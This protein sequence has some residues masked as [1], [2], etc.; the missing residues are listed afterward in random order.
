M[1]YFFYAIL[2]LCCIQCT[3]EN[4][5]SQDLSSHIKKGN[6]I[7]ILNEGQ[8]EKLNGEISVYRTDQKIIYHNVFKTVN[9]F[10]LGDIAQHLIIQNDR[11]FV[12]VNNSN[13]IYEL[14]LP[15]LTLKGAINSV[16]Y[17][18]YLALTS[19][20]HLVVSSLFFNKLYILDAG[21]RQLKSIV[22]LESP[23]ERL[24]VQDNFVYITQA[25]KKLYRLDANNLQLKDSLTLSEGGNSLVMDK[26]NKLWVLCS[27]TWDKTV[28]P[29][30]YRI[31]PVKFQ[32]ETSIPLTGMEAP[33]NLVYSSAR[34]SLAFITQ[35]LHIMALDGNQLIQSILLDPAAY[36][37][38]LAVDP[39]GSKLFVCDAGDFTSK[40]KVDQF[41]FLSIPV[42]SDSLIT[43]IAPNGV[44]FY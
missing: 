20:N 42:R 13:I 44:F 10:T 12:T 30:L 40:G 7:L 23:A 25:N 4:T 27:G 33:N 1:K 15:S 29:V 37:Y 9:N 38:G 16:P 24:L 11:M 39:E 21:T 41:Q 8:F 17:P 43:G 28:G 19:N 31:D 18:R 32:I 34:N 5:N 3:K 26:T 14:N 22:P 6:S 2:F 36:P 35:D